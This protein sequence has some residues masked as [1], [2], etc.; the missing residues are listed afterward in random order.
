MRQV[1]LG[2]V[3]RGTQGSSSHQGCDGLRWGISSELE[4]SPPWLG[5]AAALSCRRHWNGEGQ[6]RAAAD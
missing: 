6:H 2:F 5:P 1:L 3:H 4:M